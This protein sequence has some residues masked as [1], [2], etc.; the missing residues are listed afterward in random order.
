MT[1]LKRKHTFVITTSFS[2]GL[3]DRE[4]RYVIENAFNSTT[5]QKGFRNTPVKMFRVRVKG[6]VR[7]LGSQK[8]KDRAKKLKMLAD[9]KRELGEEDVQAVR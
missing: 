7:V 3:D 6:L 9:L 5:T 1:E 4:A 8:V 2:R